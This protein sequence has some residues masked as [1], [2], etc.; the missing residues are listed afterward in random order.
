LPSQGLHRTVDCHVPDEK[1]LS[2]NVA[3]VSGTKRRNE[4]RHHGKASKRRDSK[5]ASVQIKSRYYTQKEYVKLPSALKLA[6]KILRGSNIDDGNGKGKDATI[7]QVTV[8]E[9]VSSIAAAVNGKSADAIPKDDDKMTN[10][11]HPSLN[12]KS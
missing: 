9:L 4:K 8:K 12:R 2:A 10:R 7:S 6:L 3:K 11:T 5:V 1:Q